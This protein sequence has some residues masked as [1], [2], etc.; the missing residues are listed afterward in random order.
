MDFIR[1]KIIVIGTGY[2]NKFLI[3]LFDILF[4]VIGLIVLAPFFVL[5]AL[6]IV[7]DS[8]GKIIFT[9]WRVGKSNRDFRLYKFRTMHTNADRQGLITVGARDPRVTGIG[10]WL[11]RFKLDE[12]PQ[13]VNV[14]LG[15]M[16]LVGP[17]PEVRRYTEL[18]SPAHQMIVLSVKPGITDVA[19][20]EYSKENELLSNVSDPES[21]YI[22]NVLPAK[23]RLNLIFI[24]NPTFG[25]YLRII[26]KTIG[27]LFTH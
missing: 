18:Y 21:Y 24:E 9:Q 22:N 14:L 15:Q 12:L 16:S 11:R 6:L 7:L 23:V 25:N 2:M 5:I 19:S 10:I 4:S 27:K 13:L 8:P 1:K 17:R 26:F 20:I 3:R